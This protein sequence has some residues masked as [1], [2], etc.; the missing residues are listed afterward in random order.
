MENFCLVPIKAQNSVI[1][2][3]RNSVPRSDLTMVGIVRDR[4]KHLEN[5]LLTSEWV[6]DFIGSINTAWDKQSR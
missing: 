1:R 6:R 5:A 3:L 4:N 2:A